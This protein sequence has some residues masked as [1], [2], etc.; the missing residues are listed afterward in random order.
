V[1]LRV[2]FDFEFLDNLSE[3][4]RENLIYII[5]SWSEHEGGAFLEIPGGF[6]D[7]LL[8]HEFV[9]DKE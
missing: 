2:T 8:S 1:K 3:T 7:V 6:K 4:E 9:E 5:E